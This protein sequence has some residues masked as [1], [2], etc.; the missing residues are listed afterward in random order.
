MNRRTTKARDARK[1]HA[2]MVRRQLRRYLQAFR[3]RA[4]RHACD[5]GRA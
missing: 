5:R 1:A 4:F 2:A 3:S